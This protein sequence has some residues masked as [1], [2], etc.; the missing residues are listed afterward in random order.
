M[1]EFLQYLSKEAYEKR[2][3]LSMADSIFSICSQAQSFQLNRSEIPFQVDALI[4]E[5]CE[6]FRLEQLNKLKEEYGSK[7]TPDDVMFEKLNTPE[8][9]RLSVPVPRVR[10]SQKI[11]APRP[12]ISGTMFLSGFTWQAVDTVEL[13]RQLT[14][15]DYD[16]FKV[17]SIEEF[18]WWEKK[19]TLHA[20][21]RECHKVLEMKRISDLTTSMFVSSILSQVYLKNRK[22]TLSKLLELCVELFSLNNYFGVNYLLNA[23]HHPSIDRLEFTK[24]EID[25]KKWTQYEKVFRSMKYEYLKLSILAVR[26]ETFFIPHIDTHVNEVILLNDQMQEIITLSKSSNDDDDHLDPLNHHGN[27]QYVNWKKMRLKRLIQSPLYV[28]NISCRFQKVFQIQQLLRKD[29]LEQFDYPMEQFMKDSFAREGLN[30][31]RSEVL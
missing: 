18:E 20:N 4:F 21:S 14:L 1:F 2:G 30:C 28:K 29:K 26:N 7:E 6:N 16:Y 17:I 12:I 31:K 27:E 15:R 13:A 22:K 24:K 5:A 9:K 19:K 3:Y 23:I 8:K 25:Q 11:I 10:L